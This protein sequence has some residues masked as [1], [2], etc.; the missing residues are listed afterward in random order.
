MEARSWTEVRDLFSAAV[1][2]PPGERAAYVE[3]SAST[4]EVRAH[5]E[6]LLAYH[7]RPGETFGEPGGFLPRPLAPG[8]RIGHYTLV[9]VLGA[10]GMGTVYEAL[11]DRPQRKVALKTLR[12][13]FSS[14]ARLQRFLLEAEVLGTLRH[15]GIAQIH[16]AGTHEVDG[17]L[18]PWFALELVVGARDIVGYAEAR[19]LPLHARLAL[20]LEACLSLSLACPRPHRS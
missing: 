9:R 6:R 16:E 12:Q 4:A 13:G 8:E 5:V 3:R 1:E 20:F 15:P 10:G 18:F 7:E 17:Q 14:P 2:L 19:A 11:Q